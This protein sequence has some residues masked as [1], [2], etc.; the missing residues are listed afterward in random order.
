MS[1]NDH[2][3][4]INDSRLMYN[5]S[6]QYGDYRFTSSSPIP[7]LWEPNN[8]PFPRHFDLLHEDC[9]R[10]ELEMRFPEQHKRTRMTRQS[11]MEI[12][13]NLKSESV[14]AILKSDDAVC[15]DERIVGSSDDD[16]LSD[17]ISPIHKSGLSK[18][19][20][21]FGRSVTLDNNRYIEHVSIV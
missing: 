21:F 19:K 18:N 14:Y 9:K 1:Y 3:G 10:P 2:K 12:M 6:I 13:D 11:G 17:G 8:L 15:D 7:P 16:T 4:P 20:D 5:G